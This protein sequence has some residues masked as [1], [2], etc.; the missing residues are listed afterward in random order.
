[1][2]VLVHIEVR[3]GEVKK[4]S[5]KSLSE[6]ARIAS[7]T[8][9]KVSTVIVG[10]ELAGAVSASKEHGAAA[11]YTNDSAD[12]A[13]YVPEGYTASLIEAADKADAQVVMIA[14]T[15]QGRDLAPRVAAKMG[16]MLLPDVTALAVDGGELKATRP[17]YAGKVYIT[18]KA[19][20]M[21]VVI[22][23][24]P[25]TFDLARNEGAG[26]VVAVSPSFASKVKVVEVV[27][28][29]GQKLDVAEA[30][31]IVSG[32]R[33]LK[34]PENFKLLEDL[35]DKLGAA[36]GASRAVV[37]AGWRPH[38][39]QVGQTGKTVGPS[40][41]FAVGISGAVQHV[42]GMRTAKVIVAINKDADAPIFKLA[43]YGIV[44]DAMEVLP[45]LISAL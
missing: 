35:A 9:G 15:S 12:L 25:N 19:K 26:E 21:P 36:V 38:S 29:A 24:R 8:G 39:E 32:G 11:I 41:Y 20:Q 23:T 40:L 45:A 30:D 43:D 14:A 18:M 2:N 22:T 4:A 17:V 1:M 28:A 16:V 5:L 31:R 44:G 27:A 37:D 6:G 3:E 10:K 42:A 7:A 34:E 13:N 33:G